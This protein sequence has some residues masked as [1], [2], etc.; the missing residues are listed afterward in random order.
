[1][2]RSELVNRVAAQYPHLYQ[3]DIE[4]LVSAILGT[5]TALN[6]AASGYFRRA[7]G[8]PMPAATRAPE[9]LWWSNKNPSR[10]LSQRGKCTSASIRR[11]RSFWCPLRPTDAAGYPFLEPLGHR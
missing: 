9:P 2:I 11:R 4:R 5:E 3:R 6:S 7:S 1:M 8:E 10:S